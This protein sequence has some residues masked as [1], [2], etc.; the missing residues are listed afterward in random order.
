MTHLER[1][2]ELAGESLGVAYP[3]PTVGAV[4]VRDGEVV[5]EGVTEA[6]G[7][8]GE[9]VALDGRRRAGARR[10]DVRDDGALQPPGLDAAVHRSAARGGRRARR[11]GT[12]RS[13]T[14]T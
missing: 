7:R 12:A 6:D 11:R 4:V 10:D 2:L 14:R 3:K 5:G 8:H 13:R 1:A 9:A